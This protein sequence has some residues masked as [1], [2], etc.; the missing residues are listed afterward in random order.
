MFKLIIWEVKQLL[1]SVLWNG[2]IRNEVISNIVFYK[3]IFVLSVVFNLF[4]G[5]G[6][7]RPTKVFGRKFENN[8]DHESVTKTELC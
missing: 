8:E 7:A 4:W 5:L 1:I 2:S 3:K 6:L